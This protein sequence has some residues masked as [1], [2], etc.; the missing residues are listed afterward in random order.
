[1]TKELKSVSYVMPVLNEEKYLRKAVTSIL[2]QE[3]KGKVEVILALGPSTDNTN[4][5]ARELANEF[6]VILVE[7]PTGGTSAGLNAAI[8]RAEYDVVIRVDAHSVLEAHYTDLAVQILNETGA[9]NVGGVMRAVGQHR[10]QEAVAWAYNSRFGLGG[11]TFHVGGQAGPSD[12]VYL[13]VFRR[14]ALLQVGGF[15]ERVIRGQDWELNLRLRQ[16]G[17]VV[18]FDPRL[19][20]EYHPRSRWSKLAK[21]FFETGIWR[22]TLTRRSP[23]TANLRYFIPP[24]LTLGSLACVV[25]AFWL[26]TWV[27]IPVAMY[28]GAVV[29]IAATASHL[30][31]AARASLILVLPTMHYFWGAG[32]WAG[33]FSKR[34]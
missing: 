27:L 24:V 6:P 1:M 10:F 14:S 23:K 26:P 13:G 7:N 11:G 22:G 20:V 18:W 4:Q 5:I 19:Q 17:L 16:A 21:Q 15:D 30:S 25:A 9:S 28:F 32:F 12:S 34:A 3:F 31:L 33:L 8:N 29:L 2:A